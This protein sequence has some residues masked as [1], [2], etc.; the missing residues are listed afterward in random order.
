MDAKQVVDKILGQAQ[1]QAN[2]IKEQAKTKAEAELKEAKVKLEEYTKQTQAAALK[3]AEDRK[4]RILANARM[5]IRKD[6]LGAKVGLLNEVFNNSINRI[7]G[8]GDNEYKGLMK[9]L[10]LKSVETG[11]EEVVVGKDE[12]RIDQGFIDNVNREL[13]DKGK[14][15]LASDRANIKGGF[16]LRKGNISI[17]VST[18]VLV[19]QI[20]EKLE[21]EL[22]KEL[23][24]G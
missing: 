23:F 10:L 6:N 15:K 11:Q 13:G 20:R 21:M 16:I 8:F 19:S 22:N 2:E 9:K 17:N 14:L 4:G 12:H 18:A 24:E 5:D 7:N 1:S 3:E